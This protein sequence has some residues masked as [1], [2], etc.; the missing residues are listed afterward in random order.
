MWE[1]KEVPQGKVTQHLL[2][3]AGSQTGVELG[4]ATAPGTGGSRKGQGWLRSASPGA[5]EVI[6]CVFQYSLSFASVPREVRTIPAGQQ[7]IT[8]LPK[9]QRWV[10]LFGT[11][12]FVCTN[13]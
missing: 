10:M 11:Q 7:V 12:T 13:S 2:F 5:S 3:T 1:L 8:Q 6:T 9:V 4:A